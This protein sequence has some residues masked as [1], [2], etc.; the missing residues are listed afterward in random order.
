MPTIEDL[1]AALRYIDTCGS[2]AG[3]VR[4]LLVTVLEDVAVMVGHEDCGDGCPEQSVECD[5]IAAYRKRLEA[6]PDA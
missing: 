5:A 2:V 4:V 3:E 6:L 1:Y